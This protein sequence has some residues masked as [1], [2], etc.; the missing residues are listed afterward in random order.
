MKVQLPAA[1]TVIPFDWLLEAALPN[2][3]LLSKGFAIN[4]GVGL[5]RCSSLLPKLVHSQSS[6]GM[7]H[8]GD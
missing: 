8:Q 3:T 1:R 7:C 5:H 4:A 6:S 2:N